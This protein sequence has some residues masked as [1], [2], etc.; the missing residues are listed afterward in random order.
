M[1]D[2]P[3]PLS[4]V[5]EFRSSRVATGSPSP[6]LITARN[7]SA[8]PLWIVGV[9]DGSAAQARFPKW[10]GRVTGPDGLFPT[11]E[12]PDFTSPLRPRDFRKLEPGESFDPTE[13][14]S[15]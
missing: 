3:S 11:P 1:A 10:I 15:G 7:I 9:V 2:D 4:I 6:V 13:V 12:M 5:L 8:E 14:S